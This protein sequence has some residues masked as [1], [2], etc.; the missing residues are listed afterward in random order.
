MEPLNRRIDMCPSLQVF[1]EDDPIRFTSGGR[2][3]VLDAIAA[4]T[5][6]DT[7]GLVW[8]K[9]MAQQPDITQHCEYLDTAEAENQPVCDSEGWDVIQDLLFDYMIDEEIRA[10]ENH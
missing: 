5:Q 10:A 4:V 6:T 3:F 9:I 2:L 1:S 7:P 8:R